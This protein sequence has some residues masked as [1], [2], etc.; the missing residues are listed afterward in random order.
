MAAYA[1][2]RSAEAD[3]VLRVHRADAAGC[4]VRC[5]RLYPCAERASAQQLLARYATWLHPAPA[6][7]GDPHTDHQ[8]VR[9]YIRNRLRA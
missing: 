4:C 3:V 8:L 7:P 5:G 6:S 2:S 1:R 9:P